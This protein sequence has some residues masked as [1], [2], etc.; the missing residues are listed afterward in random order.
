MKKKM[1]KKSLATKEALE[2]TFGSNVFSDA[3]TRTRLPNNIY[4]MLRKT[5]DE[6]LPLDPAVADIVANAMKEWAIEKGATHFTHWFQPM[7]G[8][9]AEKHDSFISPT[10]DGRIIMEF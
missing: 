2:N 3:A 4:K 9:T 10:A 6:G 8:I 1:E 7:T 5:I